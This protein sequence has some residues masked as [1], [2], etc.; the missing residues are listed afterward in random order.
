MATQANTAAVP[1]QVKPRKKKNK[2]S[3]R[4]NNW[5]GWLFIGPYAL[6][7]SIFILI[8]VILEFASNVVDV[9]RVPGTY[10]LE[11]EMSNA[12]NAIVVNGE[13]AQSRIDEAVKTIDREIIRKLEE[14]GYIDS[15]GNTI[16]D[17]VIPSIDS[18]KVILGR[19]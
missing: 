1:Q 16:Q 2:I 15:D 9:A 6:I 8:P 3:R 4:E 11:R 10:M 18:L 7:F 17:Y 14:F 12:F 13:S 19:D 5:H